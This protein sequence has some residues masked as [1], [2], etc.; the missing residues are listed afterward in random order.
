MAAETKIAWADA[1]FNPWVGCQK[2]SAA[3]DHCYAESWAKRS[4][5]PELWTGDR[6]RTTEANWQGPIKWNRAAEKAGVRKRVFCA[7][8][9]DVFDNQVPDG[10]R[11]DLFALIEDTPS[12]TW[13][14]LTKRP[15]NIAKM[16]WPKW[17]SGLP[18]NIWLGTTAENQTEFDRRYPYLA[19]VPAHVHF[20]SYEPGLEP[21]SIRDAYPVPDWIIVGG[22]SGPKARPFDLGWA[23]TVRDQCKASGVAFFFKQ[24]GSRPIL[25]GARFATLDRS[26][27]DISEFPADLQIQEFPA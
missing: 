9:A 24:G 18:S 5:H 23:R 12:L 25:N 11:S 16:I 6:R 3:C 1:T 8:L 10:W 4:G 15:Q 20:V 17:D 19:A 22:E 14:L 26:G 2:V 7:S 21:L 13:M 27:A